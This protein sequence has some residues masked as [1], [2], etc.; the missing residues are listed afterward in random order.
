MANLI[1]VDVCLYHR[2]HNVA[3]NLPGT[4][5]C[6]VKFTRWYLSV[7]SLLSSKTTQAI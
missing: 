5:F 7:V 1:P 3:G 4:S 2:L 6:P